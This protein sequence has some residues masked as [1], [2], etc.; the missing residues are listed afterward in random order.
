M[1]KLSAVAVLSI[2]IFSS[3]AS[4]SCHAESPVNDAGIPPDPSLPVDA[5]ENK[6]LQAVAAIEQQDWLTA[7]R[8]TE[9]LVKSFPNFKLGEL[10]DEI[11]ATRSS[12]PNTRPFPLQAHEDEFLPAN[13]AAELTLRREA[14]SDNHA[15]TLLPASILRLGSDV[16]YAFVVDLEESRFYV[17]KNDDSRL[18]VVADYY[19]GIGK[20]GFNKQREGDHRTPVGIYTV[21]DHLTDDRL[22][23]LYGVGA[24]TLDY[25]NPWDRRLERTGSGIWLHGVPRN[26][27]SRPPRSSRGCVTLSNHLFEA[28][29]KLSIPGNTVIITE[30]TIE[31]QEAGMRKIAGAEIGAVLEQWRQDWAS[32]DFEK[33]VSHYSPD[34]KTLR[35]DYQRWAARK[36]AVNSGKKFINVELENIS[37]FRYPGE[38]N[39]LQVNYRQHYQ[40]N[41]FNN[42]TDK[43]QY[44]RK[45]SDGRWQIVYE[46][47]RG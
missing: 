38:E 33:Y 35:G 20:Q 39:L 3:F 36:R 42:S 16:H 44:W 26:T 28:I 47:P 6:L 8:E 22:P 11:I 10:L 34:F 14:L 7:S 19:A 27:Y 25:P 45:N 21:V 17:V 4:L 37:I 12:I 30:P 29:R 15:H 31:W 9:E 43:I 2:F 24:L 23:E 18:A 1:K 13:L 32:L 40:S 46:G 5:A 41:N